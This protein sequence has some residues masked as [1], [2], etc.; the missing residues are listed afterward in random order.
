MTS[1][2]VATSSSPRAREAV[3][4]I[5]CPGDRSV[6][7]DH[8]R[9][10]SPHPCDR[11]SELRSERPQGVPVP[12][13]QSSVPPL[14]HRAMPAR[15]GLAGRAEFAWRAREGSPGH[16]QRLPRRPITPARLGEQVSALGIR[17]LPARRATLLQLAAEV[18]AAVLAE[19]L[20]LTPGTAHPVSRRSGERPIQLVASCRRGRGLSPRRATA[21]RRRGTD[22]TTVPSPRISVMSASRRFEPA[23]ASSTR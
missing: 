8:V 1:A 5:A 16:G 15:Q 2:S 3:K 14:D 9:S 17:A 7:H 22:R 21:S 10:G 18:P 23:P 19:L 4:K 12:R 11:L 13:Q 6:R 20:H